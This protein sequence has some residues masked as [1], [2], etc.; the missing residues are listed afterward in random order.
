MLYLMLRAPILRF[1][2]KRYSL[3]F[4]YFSSAHDHSCLIKL[5]RHATLDFLHSET[6]RYI[7]FSVPLTA[8]CSSWVAHYPRFCLIRYFNSPLRYRKCTALSSPSA[9]ESKSL[10]GLLGK[11]FSIQYSLFVFLRWVLFLF[12]SARQ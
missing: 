2:I 1:A 3:L 6:H 12:F 9:I 4:L 10:M 8:L 7:R 11:E 5:G